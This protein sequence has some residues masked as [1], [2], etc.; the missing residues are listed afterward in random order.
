MNNRREVC[1]QDTSPVIDSSGY[2]LIEIP[3]VAEVFVQIYND[4]RCSG[5]TTDSV[6]RIDHHGF[7]N[8]AYIT[9]SHDLR[10]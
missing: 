1:Q 10:F 3:F 2:L 8:G 4:I 5:C 6:D 9:L 7:G